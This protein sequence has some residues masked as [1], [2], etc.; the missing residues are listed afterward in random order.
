MGRVYM[1]FRVKYWAWPCKSIWTGKIL[2]SL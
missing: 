2:F 1:V